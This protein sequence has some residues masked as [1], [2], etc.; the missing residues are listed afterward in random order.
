MNAK[1]MGAAL[2]LGGAAVAAVAATDAERAA[3]EQ[4]IRL[5]EKLIADSATA[6]RIA[7]SGNPRAVSHFDEG[8]LHH[9][10]ASDLL[11]QGDVD[12]ARKAV[13]DALRHVA[14]ARRLVPDGTARQAQ[15]KARYEQGRANL[16]R[17]IAS[18]RARAGAG[19]ADDGDLV[20]A[21]GLTQTAQWFAAEQ[22]FE[23]A[24]HTLDAAERHVLA[25]MNRLLGAKTL[26][27]TARASSPAEEY[28]IELARHQGLADL[29]PLALRELRPRSDA[30]VLIE[31][32]G[33]SSK[34][35]R[36]Q[37]ERRFQAGEV[38]P[39]L[40]DIRN[41]TL[42]VQRALGAAGV[43]TPAAAEGSTP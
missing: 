40:A 3:V 30:L 24:G 18:W 4:R 22:R 11:K 28:Q 25:G 1:L 13:D 38:Q 10:H 8:R 19:E 29:L 27:Y 17:L 20:A 33:E 35:L 36:T 42:F 31:R 21:I 2:L 37:A 43:V 6:Q 9:A 12:G 34:A 23:E 15:A 14:M 26:D 41:A 5:T 7:T 16:E 39:A 32:Y